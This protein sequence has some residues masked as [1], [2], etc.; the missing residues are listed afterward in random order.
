MG[1]WNPTFSKLLLSLQ[2][3]TWWSSSQLSSSSSS[4]NSRVSQS[5]QL[6]QKSRGLLRGVKLQPPL[7]R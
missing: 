6:R 5:N 1:A 4:S 7:S 3:S 2:S